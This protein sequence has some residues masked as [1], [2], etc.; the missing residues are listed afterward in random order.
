MSDTGEDLASIDDAFGG[1]PGMQ[2]GGEDV[3]AD[4][5]AI[6]QDVAPAPVEAPA[7]ADPEPPAAEPTE[8]SAPVPDWQAYGFKTPD[9]M[10]A[11]YKE[12]QRTLTAQRQPQEAEE[13]W[14]EE[15]EDPA[16]TP[17]WQSHQFQALGEIPRVGLSAP[18]REQ[19]ADLMGVDPKAAALWALKNQEFM[20]PQDFKAVQN[21]WAQADPH[22]YHEFRDALRTHL[23]HQARTEEEASR[24]AYVLERQRESAINEAKRALPIMEERGEEFG[25][26]LEAPENR[27]ISNM[28]DGIQDPGRLRNALVS[29]FYQYAGPQLYQELMASHQQAAELA[30]QQQAQ[31]ETEAQAQ[32]KT[33][34]RA[35]TQTRTA[36]SST[37][38][39]EDSDDAIR[40][41]IGNPWGN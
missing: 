40:A 6:A 21:N 8:E 19:L 31:A 39:A 5:A 38:A 17:T 27:D 18:Q 32:A 34:R 26:W 22:E 3:P 36:A 20:E 7:A 4:D 15:E 2:T 13:E 25:K 14:E 9:D 11:S 16:Q 37:P 28:L 24:N 35:S 33:G 12:L 29:A 41:A 1:W 10:Y 23:E 30:A